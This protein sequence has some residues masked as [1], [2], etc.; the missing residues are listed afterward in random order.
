MSVPIELLNGIDFISAE[1]AE[2][3]I[4]MS[5]NYWKKKRFEHFSLSLIVDIAPRCVYG[6]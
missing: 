3:M 1:M 6:R 4:V 2:F 5:A